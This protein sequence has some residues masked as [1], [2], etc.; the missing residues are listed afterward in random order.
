MTSGLHSGNKKD[1]EDATIWQWYANSV[2]MNANDTIVI[3][4]WCDI[5]KS[6]VKKMTMLFEVGILGMTSF[7]EM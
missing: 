7:L 1:S 2:L 5:G 6:D 3:M 4:K